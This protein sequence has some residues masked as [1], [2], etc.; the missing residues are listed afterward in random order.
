MAE[1]YPIHLKM[2]GVIAVVIGGGR[3]ASRKVH[4]LLEG[5]ARVSVVSPRIVDSIETLVKNQQVEWREKFFSPDDL[6]GAT[7]VFACTN[8]MVTNENVVHSLQPGQWINVADRPD[9]STF[10]V[11]AHFR[12]GMVTISV[13]TDGASPALARKIKEKLKEEVDGAYGPY[14]EFLASCRKVILERI[15]NEA[16]RRELFYTL[17]KEEF[18]E[19]FRRNQGDTA[20]NRFARLVEEASGQEAHSKGESGH[21]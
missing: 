21:E 1:T 17:L 12:R 4:S 15:T 13:A 18:L 8:H 20:V 10:Y 2:V 5:G 14:G 16:I 9:L 19:D 3:V 7:L 6:Q 11:P